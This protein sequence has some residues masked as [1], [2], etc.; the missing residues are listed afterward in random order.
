MIPAGWDR[1]PTA[2]EEQGF[3][4][5]GWDE[6]LADGSPAET[7]EDWTWDEILNE[8]GP[9]NFDGHPTADDTNE[10]R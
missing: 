1:E 3:E 6:R 4:G 7:M 5:D 9:E 2:A 10:E 8:D